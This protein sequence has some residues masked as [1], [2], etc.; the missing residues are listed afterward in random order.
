MIFARRVHICSA[1]FVRPHYLVGPSSSEL[2][3]PHYRRG[4][5][6]IVGGISFIL[7]A[8]LAVFILDGGWMVFGYLRLRDVS[9]QDSIFPVFLRVGGL[10]YSGLVLAVIHVFARVCRT[11][12][13]V[14]AFFDAA[15]R[16]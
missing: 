4:L 13:S 12:G 11:L 1:P 9:S 5:S 3:H 8:T 10:W 16:T 6:F 14:K 7:C 2:H 15:S